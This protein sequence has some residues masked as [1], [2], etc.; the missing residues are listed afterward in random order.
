MLLTLTAS[1][2]N[3]SFSFVNLASTHEE[4]K[5]IELEGISVTQIFLHWIW[6]LF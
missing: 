5:P 2:F 3:N 4:E 1:T 6:N